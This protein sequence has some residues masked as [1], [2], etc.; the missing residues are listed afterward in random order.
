MSLERRM[1]P[2]LCRFKARAVGSP[3]SLNCLGVNG[4]GGG[5]A[6]SRAPSF[7]SSSR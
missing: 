2:V 1:S 7:L 3:R 4:F 6:P 5:S